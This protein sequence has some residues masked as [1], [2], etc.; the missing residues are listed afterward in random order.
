MKIKI[1]TSACIISRTTRKILLARRK[2][3]PG[4]GLLCLPGGKIHPNE[5]LRDG[6]IRE[7][8]EEVGLKTTDYRISQP[9]HMT[10]VLI[11]PKGQPSSSEKNESDQQ[12]FRYVLVQYA[13]LVDHELGYLRPGDDADLLQWIDPEKDLGIKSISFEDAIKEQVGDLEGIL[14]SSNR[15]EKWRNVDNFEDAMNIDDALNLEYNA[16]S[17]AEEMRTIQLFEEMKFDYQLALRSDL[18]V[19]RSIIPVISKAMDLYDSNRLYFE[20]V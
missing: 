12:G 4:A 6:V 19:M 7:I 11:E 10:D 1:A 16:K 8:F 2:N 3:S 5:M 13:M 20:Q 17:R 9:F 18:P 14:D 15:E